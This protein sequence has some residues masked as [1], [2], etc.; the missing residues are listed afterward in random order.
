MTSLLIFVFAK[1]NSSLVHE[2]IELFVNGC[3]CL[4]G[5]LSR[6]TSENQVHDTFLFI[7]ESVELCLPLCPLT[8]HFGPYRS[9]DPSW[10]LVS[11]FWA[12]GVIITLLP[13]CVHI[14]GMPSGPWSVL[15]CMLHDFGLWVFLVGYD[16]YSCIVCLFHPYLKEEVYTLSLFFPGVL[17]RFFL[18]RTSS[19][20]KETRV[21]SVIQ[22][23]LLLQG[24]SSTIIEWQCRIGSNAIGMDFIF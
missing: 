13:T 24:W 20:S 3:L 7:S 9:P 5:S 1:N 15:S 6:I 10:H 8:S 11:T 16:H 18:G 23:G 14:V 21:S 12:K 4:L 17:L 22:T 2:G 19:L